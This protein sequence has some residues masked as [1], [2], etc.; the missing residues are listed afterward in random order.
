L[1]SL[2]VSPKIKVP[3]EPTSAKSFSMFKRGKCQAS[4]IKKVLNKID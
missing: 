1:T 3:R 4:K 2:G